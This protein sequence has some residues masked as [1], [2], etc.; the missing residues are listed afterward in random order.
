MTIGPVSLNLVSKQE[1]TE[2][3][4]VE[5]KKKNNIISRFQEHMYIIRHK[6]NAC[7][8]SEAFA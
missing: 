6:R 1:K 8:V 5:K 2:A 3:K 7:K 4:N